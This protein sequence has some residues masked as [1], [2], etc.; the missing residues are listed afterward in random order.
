MLAA[1]LGRPEK[2]ACA[3]KCH[4]PSL[5]QES[6]LAPFQSWGWNLET[7]FCVDQ[8]SAVGMWGGGGVGRRVVEMS[9]K[10]LYF[11]T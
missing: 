1:Q 11:L 7:C 3:L 4:L 6:T 10:L 2:N 9:Y 5:F 8:G